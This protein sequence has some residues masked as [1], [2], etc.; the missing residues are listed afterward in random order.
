[1]YTWLQSGD[2]SC[3]SC[4]CGECAES[5][6][7]GQNADNIRLG[8]RQDHLIDDM[9]DSIAGSD[10][11]LGNSGASNRYSTFESK[12][13]LVSSCFRWN[14]SILTPSQTDFSRVAADERNGTV[15]QSAREDGARDDVTQQDLL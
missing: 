11:S 1:M 6:I 15:R 10:I 9:D 4:G 7:S 5:A 13:S 2:Q 8:S 14:E 12:E 3:S